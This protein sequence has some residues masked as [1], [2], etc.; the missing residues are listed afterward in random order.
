MRDRYDRARLDAEVSEHIIHFFVDSAES[1]RDMSNLLRLM[2][3]SFHEDRLRRLLGMSSLLSQRE[4]HNL[5]I[6]VSELVA[7]AGSYGDRIE[8]IRWR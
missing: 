5:E 7:Y 1:A 8:A 6:V 3:Y 2:F 4:I